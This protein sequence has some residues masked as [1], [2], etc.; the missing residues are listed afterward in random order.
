MILLYK[1]TSLLAGQIVFA[2]KNKDAADYCETFFGAVGQGSTPPP[3]GS[4]TVHLFDSMQNHYL[5]TYTPTS[6]SI[7]VQGCTYNF[8]GP[9]PNSHSVEGMYKVEIDG[10]L[11]GPACPA[12]ESSPCFQSYWVTTG[13]NGIFSFVDT[14]SAA[15]PAFFAV[16]N[17][18]ANQE[19]GT[20]T[21]AGVAMLQS[22]SWVPQGYSAAYDT[23]SRTVEISSPGCAGKYTLNP[24]I[25]AAALTF[26]SSAPAPQGGS[27]TLDFIGASSPS[28]PVNC[29][30]NGYNSA[31]DATGEAVP[32]QFGHHLLST[33][34]RNSIIRLDCL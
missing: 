28:C 29:A 11:H 31:W 5:A 17:E 23:I 4:G 27:A 30:S 32:A 33:S 13:V 7:D 26:P 24:A 15:C 12:V 34:S 25:P 19:Q 16:A 20:M 10:G 18:G 22:T 21:I 2:P 3:A 1:L 6:F 9:K 8:G 14:A